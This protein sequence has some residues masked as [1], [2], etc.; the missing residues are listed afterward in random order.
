MNQKVKRSGINI[1]LGIVIGFIYYF[2]LRLEFL[3][4]WM[5]YL[6][7]QFIFLGNILPAI[8]VSIL[9]ACI[10]GKNVK[11]RIVNTLQISI[12]SVLSFFLIFMVV[13]CNTMYNFDR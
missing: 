9:L 3:Y 7:Q 12:T 10:I 6:P 4:K 8:V 2:S 5:R 11:D 1:I 13:F